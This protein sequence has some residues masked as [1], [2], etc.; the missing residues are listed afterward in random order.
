MLGDTRNS[1][2]EFVAITLLLALAFGRLDANLL[3]VLLKR[4]EVLACFGELTLLH[5]L[6]NIPMHKGALRVHQVELMVDA[7]EDLCDGGRVADHAAC[8]HDLGQVASRDHRRRLVIDTALESGGTPIDKL[9]GALRLDRGNRC[10]D[11]LGHDIAAVHHAAC[12]V[13]AVT[14]V[15]LHIHRGWLKDRH[16][17]LGHGKLLVVG[18]LRRD[19][20]RIAREHEVDPRVG[21]EVCLELGDVH[22]KGS[23]KAQ[24]SCQ[25]RDDLRQEAVQVSVGGPLDVEI[26]AADVVERL[27]VHHDGHVGV[28]EQGVHAQHGVVGFD[29]CRRNLGASPHCEAQL[30]L[31]AIVHGQALEHQATQ[32]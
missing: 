6:P 30:R 17:D 28:L 21:D 24:R 15:A 27:V 23:V 4:S 3:V 13:L 8:T 11:V 12:H 26:P 20:R 5:A 9:D 19:H 10:I 25:G 22:V 29:H 14:G 7:R 32:A 31:L 1:L 16:R 2:S 18:L